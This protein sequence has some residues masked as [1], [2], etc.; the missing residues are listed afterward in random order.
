MYFEVIDEMKAETQIRGAAL[1]K[2]KIF[3]FH[4]F[5]LEFLFRLDPGISLQLDCQSNKLTDKNQSGRTTDVL[6]VKACLPQEL[7]FI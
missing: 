7:D 2:R 6:W 4:T 1:N 5:A 3:I